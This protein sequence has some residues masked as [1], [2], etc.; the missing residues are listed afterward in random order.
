MTNSLRSLRA[1]AFMFAATF[2]VSFPVDSKGEDSQWVVPSADDLHRARAEI[3]TA[4]DALEQLLIQSPDVV[5]WKTY[6]LWSDLQQAIDASVGTDVVELAEARNRLLP[7][8][9]RLANDEAGLERDEVQSLRIAVRRHVRQINAL[10]V[11]RGS[12]EA[13]ARRERLDALVTQ[14]RWTA[15][16]QSE[17]HEHLR[18]LDDHLQPPPSRQ[19]LSHFSN[20]TASISAGFIRQS[21]ATPVSDPTDVNE[22]IVGTR[23]IGTGVTSGVGWLEPTAS[24]DGAKLVARF[25]GTLNSDT[26]GYNGPVRIY[27]DGQ[28]QLTGTALLQLDD[29][30][31]RQLSEH[32]DASADSQTK[33][34]STR[35]RGLLDKIV[36]RVARKKAAESKSQANWES[37]YKAR[38]S[39]SGRFATDIA[40]QVAEGD[41]SFQRYLRMPLLRRDL[42]PQ[43]WT[44]GSD[45]SALRTFMSF[46]GR[47]R[48]SSPVAVP[49]RFAVAGHAS[50]ETNSG[51]RLAIHQS[52][53]DN[54]AEG[55]LGGQTQRLSELAELSQSSEG[56][57]S[58]GEEVLIVLD[59]F[60]PVR[61][62]FDND[63]LTFHLLPKQ[64]VTAGREAG[65]V[66]IKVA[67]RIERGAHGLQLRRVTAPA[68]EPQPT[69]SRPP[70]LAAS[71]SAIRVLVE[72]RLETELPETYP[73]KLPAIESSTSNADLPPSVQNLQITDIQAF[74]GWLYISLH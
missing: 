63:T 27:S 33:G 4:M 30:G 26:V 48:P 5:A 19:V 40:E 34:I 49:G 25:Q 65:G 50:A 7:I 38:Q 54:A 58:E 16:A 13:K 59:D 10:L 9:S 20:L 24:N 53:I 22:C 31:L 23:V 43:A 72:P 8:Y 74:G 56:E 35:F 42:I 17:Y 29:Q 36:K 15:A 70:R 44:W 1:A 41:G 64:I 55:Y 2:V 11:R 47:D 68:I 37:S 62:I 57:E 12:Q 67:Y 66:I 51:L 39:F 52:F 18:W 6:L 45:A 14:N 32:V 61:T 3:S 21:T 46:D 71:G 69:Y 60:Q 73:L 28:T